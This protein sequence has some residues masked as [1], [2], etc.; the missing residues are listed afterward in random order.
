[1][2]VVHGRCPCVLCTVQARR[3]ASRTQTPEKKSLVMSCSFAVPVGLA[4]AGL[5]LAL[6]AAG[7]GL[8][9]AAVGLGLVATDG[10]GRGLRPGM[11]C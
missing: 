10:D 2:T 6:A 1:M 8:G 11:T 9:L 7:L 5:G 3:A 4:A